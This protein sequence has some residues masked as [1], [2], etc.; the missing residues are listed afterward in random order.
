MPYMHCS[1]C[2][3]PTFSAAKHSSR[4]ECPRCGTELDPQRRPAGAP[5]L[6]TAD[7]A[8]A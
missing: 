7:E 1:S 3:L 4:D 8:A 2:R 6:H 5:P